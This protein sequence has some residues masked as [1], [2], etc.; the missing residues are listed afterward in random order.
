METCSLNKLQSKGLCLLKLKL[1]SK[2]TGLYGRSI[3]SLVSGTI[4]KPINTQNFSSGDIVSIS[5]NSIPP[6]ELNNQEKL[7]SGTVTKVTIS[8]ISI[9]IDNDLETIDEAINDNDLYKIIKLSN[10]ITYK[11]IKNALLSIQNQKLNNL[12]L[13]SVDI[14]F[15]AREATQ[16]ESS[17]QLNIQFFNNKLDESQRE[18][19]EFTFKQKDLAIIH[20]PPGTGKTTTLVEII[21]QSIFKFKLK[22]LC[23]APSNI[24]VDNLVERLIPGEK[25]FSRIKMIRL[26]HPA[27]LLETIQDYCLDS[28]ISRSDQ[29]KLT[30]DI[31]DEMDNTLKKL[32]RTNNKGEREGYKR[33][34]RELRKELYKREEKALKNVLAEADIILAT[35]TTAHEDG[36]LKHLKDD[37]FDLIIIDECSQALEAAC[38]IPIVKGGRKLVIAGD[39]LQLPPTIISKDAAEK[40]LDLT[41]MKRLIDTYGADSTKML[42]IQYRMNEKIMDWISGKL[43]ESKLTAHV[44]VAHHLLIDLPL[45]KTCDETK[46]PIL[47]IDTEGCDMYEMVAEDSLNDE[48]SKANEG[49]ANLVCT[50][51]TNLIQS[52]LKQE[53]IAV[54][55]PYNLQVELIRAKLHPKYPLVEVKSVD[56][57]QGREKEAVILSLVRSNNH[58]EVGFLADQRRINVA[59]TRARR[60]LCVVCDT[61]TCKNNEFL[62][63]FI[64]YCQT[65][66]LIQSA[67]DYDEVEETENEFESLKFGKLRVAN[68]KPLKKTEKQIKEVKKVNK[69]NENTVKKNDEMIKTDED[70]IFQAETIKLIEKL[71]GEHA[72]PSSLTARQRKIV[73]EL[74]EKYK[75]YHQSKGENE[76]RF[77]IISSQPIKTED[78]I[79]MVSK[80]EPVDEDEQQNDEPENDA[81]KTI[82]NKFSTLEVQQTQIKS[83][84]KK[85]KKAESQDV[86]KKDTENSSLIGTLDDNSDLKFRSDCTMCKYCSKFILLSNFQM[87]ELHCSKMN[88]PQIKEPKLESEKVKSATSTKK[89]ESKIKQVDFSKASNDFDEL[90][91]MSE[92]LNNIC[93]FDKCKVKIQILGQTCEFCRHRFCLQHSL[94]EVHGCGDAA[95]QSARSHIRQTGNLNTNGQSKSYQ[96]QLKRDYAEKK[97]KEKIQNMQKER[98]RNDSNKKQK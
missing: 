58:G 64:D 44:S 1:D 61:R 13:N 5:E 83:K 82:E 20:G 24:A 37:H 42:T 31:K 15:G 8:S 70:L 34:M 41:L 39:H 84:K 95:K 97:L 75:L 76:Q 72:F 73:H 66:A 6:H 25:G 56:G 40:G 4:G 9:A 21:K 79:T 52:G 55:T 51:V 48:E 85:N 78:K 47:L 32:R 67:F 3:I 94:A 22:I 88:R 50:H 27:R 91:E 11:R 10:D 19:I 16:N 57:F 65:N 46:T 59:I 18:A 93:N 7:L 35:L 54:I 38:W 12:A 80:I 87:H 90:I 98:G 33:E 14:L 28:V 63:S 77:I 53:Q 86:L 45:I 23:C 96:D 49:E 26:G 68:K 92:K 17:R 81:L 71:D 60:H 29:F 30:E 89:P 43:Y 62:K 74:A 69:T 36:P 2:H